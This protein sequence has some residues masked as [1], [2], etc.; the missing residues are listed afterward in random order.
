M[1]KQT[2]KS[3]TTLPGTTIVRATDTYLRDMVAKGHPS[4]HEAL[5]ELRRR[6]TKRS[7]DGLTKLLT[8]SLTKWAAESERN[9]RELCALEVRCRVEDTL[10]DNGVRPNASA[11]ALTKGRASR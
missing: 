10:S 9:E 6:L 4:R 5:A 3:L 7:S 2:K 11:H 1:T 8:E